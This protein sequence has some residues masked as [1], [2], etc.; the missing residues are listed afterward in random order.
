MKNINQSKRNVKY[1]PPEKSRRSND[2]HC[3]EKDA[4][5]VNS[6]END[7]K[8]KRNNNNNNNNDDVRNNVNIN[9]DN[10]YKDVKDDDA[11]DDDNNLEYDRNDYIDKTHH[12]TSNVNDKKVKVINTDQQSRIQLM[13]D[14]EDNKSHA[15]VWDTYE[16][17]LRELKST[18]PTL[19]FQ[20]INDNTISINVQ[21]RWFNILVKDNREDDQPDKY[22]DNY[23]GQH[24]DI[25]QDRVIRV[26]CNAMKFV[27]NYVIFKETEASLLEKGE[28][29][30][31]AYLVVNNA[32]DKYLHETEDSALRGKEG[33]YSFV[34]RIGL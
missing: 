30:R 2:L 12:D 14:N 16:T 3:S 7:H 4:K 23:H 24:H 5:V 34:G 10:D 6:G 15:H 19:L 20:V 13:I 1:S 18:Y 9:D 31:G 26:D 11:N 28:T 32:D 29:W 21:G 25:H 22:N 17:T 27:D 8:L 33:K